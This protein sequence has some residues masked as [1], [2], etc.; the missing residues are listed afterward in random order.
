MGFDRSGRGLIPVRF[1][2]ETTEG[3]QHADQDLM[4]PRCSLV[5]MSIKRRLAM[6][7]VA[8]AAMAAIPASLVLGAWLGGAIPLHAERALALATTLST[9]V[10]WLGMFRLAMALVVFSRLVPDEQCLN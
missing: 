10:V 7:G 4:A 6:L 9:V 5:I 3:R 2:G 8:A 1:V